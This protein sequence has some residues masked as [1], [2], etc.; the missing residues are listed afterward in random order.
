[1]ICQRADLTIATGCA[2]ADIPLLVIDDDNILNMLNT[3]SH[4]T[5]DTES[6]NFITLTND[7]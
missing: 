7:D 2:V 6:D 4:V 3:G 5:L 1:M